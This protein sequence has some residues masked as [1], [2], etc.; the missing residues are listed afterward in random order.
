MNC[1]EEI[2]HATYI[3]KEYSRASDCEKNITNTHNNREESEH[4][5]R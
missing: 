4:N 2:Y 1:T 5:M 3:R